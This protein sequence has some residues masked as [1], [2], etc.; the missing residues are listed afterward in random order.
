MALTTEEGTELL[1]EYVG[2]SADRNDLLARCWATATGLVVTYAGTSVVP[3]PTL[4]MA[5]L[6]VAAELFQRQSAP[7]GIAQFQHLTERQAF[8]L[9]VIRCCRP[10]PS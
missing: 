8:V 5:I 2:A 1:R 4:E 3:A 9:R 7:N 6:Q 10:I